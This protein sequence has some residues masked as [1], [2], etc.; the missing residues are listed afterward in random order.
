MKTKKFFDVYTFQN[1]IN[2]K[3]LNLAIIQNQKVE[4]KSNSEGTPSTS[5]GNKK[6]GRMQNRRKISRVLGSNSVVNEHKTGGGNR[7]GALKFYCFQN[8]V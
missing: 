3:L 5:G 8:K 4:E 2:L 1:L 6:V 7:T